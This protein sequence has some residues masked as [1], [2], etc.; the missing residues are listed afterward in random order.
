VDSGLPFQ[1]SIHRAASTHPRGIEGQAIAGCLE[2]AFKMPRQAMMR[3]PQVVRQRGAA[4]HRAGG[5][6]NPGLFVFPR[7][8]KWAKFPVIDRN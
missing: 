1:A 6:R 2:S 8:P 7:H 5:Y 4:C 3:L